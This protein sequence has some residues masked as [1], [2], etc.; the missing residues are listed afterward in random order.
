MDGG[1]SGYSYVGEG[2]SHEDSEMA[3]GEQAPPKEAEAPE[4]ETQ[5][6]PTGNG[7]GKLAWG[8]KVS[9]EFRDKVQEIAKTTGV[10]ANALMAIMAFESG[11]SFSASK[12]NGTVAVGLI[13]F[14]GSGAASVGSTKEELSKMTA[15]QQLD[16]VQKYLQNKM[17]T[18]KDGTTKLG[19]VQD[20]Y[21]AI[22][23]PA[24]VGKGGDYVL[25]TKDSGKLYT[26]N[27]GLD[28]NKD[29]KV[30]RDEAASK[31]IDSL[32]LGAE[33]AY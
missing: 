13:Q 31:A 9:Q 24:A 17:F 21:M 8:A 1:P 22:H 25:Y 27:K 32:R 15:V 20:L 12:W 14:T 6:T 4:P 19:S 10:D 11:G 2:T 16:Y 3:S 29:G 23:W 28:V 5:E 30:T 33:Y 18:N 26:L 7:D